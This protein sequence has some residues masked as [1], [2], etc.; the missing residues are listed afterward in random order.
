[1]LGETNPDDSKVGTIRFDLSIRVERNVCD[2]SFTLEDANREI[3]LFFQDKE[4]VSWND[5]SEY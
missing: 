3:G 4:I 1:M 2:A 5:H